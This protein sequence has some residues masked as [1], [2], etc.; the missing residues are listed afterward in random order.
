M[1]MVKNTSLSMLAEEGL[2]GFG[3]CSGKWKMLMVQA[4]PRWLYMDIGTDINIYIRYISDVCIRR[5]C[6]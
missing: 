6:I 1:A 4:W 5:V 2:C 3:G